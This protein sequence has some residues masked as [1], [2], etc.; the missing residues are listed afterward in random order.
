MQILSLVDKLALYFHKNE[1]DKGD[2]V[3]IFMTNR[4]DY[5]ALILA[6]SRLGTVACLLNTHLKRKMLLKRVQSINCKALVV[7]RDLLPSI[8]WV[9]QLGE[10]YLTLF[11]P[12]VIEEI[13]E[14]LIA[15][16]IK[17]YLYDGPIQDKAFFNLRD[18]LIKIKDE[19]L[20]L[21]YQVRFHD[22]ILYTFTGNMF[23]YTSP[24]VVSNAK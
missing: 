2:V 19:T 18:E 11:F 16:K 20:E 8:E 15:K 23:G 5:I 9:L 7:S 14:E 4:P 17:L 22:R 3:G 6:F 21:Q 10:N 1:F 12:L 13:K 24:S